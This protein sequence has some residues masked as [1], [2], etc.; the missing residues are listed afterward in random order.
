VFYFLLLIYQNKFYQMVK[1]LAKEATSKFVL[2]VLL[3]VRITVFSVGI[4]VSAF[5]YNL[6]IKNQQDIQY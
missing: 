2:A 6:A 5:I 3:S 4:N 1:M